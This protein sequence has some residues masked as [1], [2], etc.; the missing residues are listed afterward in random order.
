MFEPTFGVKI[1]FVLLSVSDSLLWLSVAVGTQLS[2]NER[3]AYPLGHVQLPL[4][5]V[6]LK[7]FQH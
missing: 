1:Y 4:L 7:I 6:A 3:I 2:I 5:T